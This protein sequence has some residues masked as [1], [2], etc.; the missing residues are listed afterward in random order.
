[1]GSQIV[2][3]V[4]AVPGLQWTVSDDEWPFF[5]SRIP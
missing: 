5:A 2:G 3:Q 1:M 4:V